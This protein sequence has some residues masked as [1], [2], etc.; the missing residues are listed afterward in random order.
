MAVIPKKVKAWRRRQP[1]G[2]I[3]APETFRKIATEATRRYGSQERGKRVAGAAY[4]RTVLAKF[5]AAVRRAMR[6]K[7]R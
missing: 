4:W 7:R 1:H 5:R 2:A 6:R 3:M